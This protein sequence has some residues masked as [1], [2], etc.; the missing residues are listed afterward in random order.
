MKYP[1][2]K[3][4]N[5][6]TGYT[7]ITFESMNAIVVVKGVPANVCN[8]CWGHASRRNLRVVHAVVDA[9]LYVA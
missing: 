5:I 4:V 2:W 8:N 3:G 1:I 6:G 9:A 7:S